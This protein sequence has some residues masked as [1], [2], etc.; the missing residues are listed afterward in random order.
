[1]TMKWNVALWTGMLSN[2]LTALAGN[3]EQPHA[4]KV[5][6]AGF[7][8]W[9]GV[10]LII[11]CLIL[12]GVCALSFLKMQ[13]IEKSSKETSGQLKVLKKRLEED[14]I[15]LNEQV[16]SLEYQIR[17]VMNLVESKVPSSKPQSGY[18]VSDDYT[19]T[20]PSSSPQI[21]EKGNYKDKHEDI[22]ESDIKKEI[23]YGSPQNG[24]FSRGVDTFVPGTS[25]YCVTDNGSTEASYTIA[26]RK[27]AKT[28]IRR[29]LSRFLEPAC[30]I[31]GNTDKDF[32]DIIVKKQ[33]RV[34]KISGGW[35]II[36]KAFVE[37]IEK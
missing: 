18:G 36:K 1:M 16:K 10:I 11:L 33:G 24:V 9:A 2:S 25:L 5:V 17:V 14:K 23:F 4:T 37:L 30:D 3:G 29:S 6:S 13:K 32:S 12:I 31:I 35:K 21:S 27:E 28:V 19:T 8:I 15:I 22:S 26:D 20:H 34:R 7:P